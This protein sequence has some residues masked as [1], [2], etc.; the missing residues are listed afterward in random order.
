MDDTPCDEREGRRFERRADPV[1]CEKPRCSTRKRTDKDIKKERRREGRLLYGRGK[2]KETLTFSIHP[3]GPFL[4]LW[5]IIG[6]P[7]GN[8]PPLTIRDDA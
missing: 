4:S 2:T 7:K 8:P 3:S 1:G 6:G 5:R